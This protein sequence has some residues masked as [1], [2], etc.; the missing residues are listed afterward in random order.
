MGNAIRPDG[1]S[2]NLK[3]EREDQGMTGFDESVIGD[4]YGWGGMLS[5]HAGNGQEMHPWLICL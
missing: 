5:W 4:E 2:S 3:V 1:R